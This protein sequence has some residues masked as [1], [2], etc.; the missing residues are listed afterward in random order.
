METL[1][2]KG[3]E[4]VP[5]VNSYQ[6]NGRTRTNLKELRSLVRGLPAGMA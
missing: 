1:D 4:F 2:K 6:T 5:F 3:K